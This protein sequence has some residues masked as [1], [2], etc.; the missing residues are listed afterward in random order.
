M[1]KFVN[2][3]LDAISWVGAILSVVIL[4]VLIRVPNAGKII[5]TITLFIVGCVLAA[6]ILWLIQTTIKEA[7]DVMIN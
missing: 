4:A 2:R 6:L 5:A 1:K 3:H 7:I